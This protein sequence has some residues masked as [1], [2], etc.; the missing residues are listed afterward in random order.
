[1]PAT[2]SISWSSS[3]E[4]VIAYNSRRADG[5]PA[6][7]SAKQPSNPKAFVHGTATVPPRPSAAV[8]AAS[9]A[10]VI[11]LTEGDRAFFAQTL[12][13]MAERIQKPRITAATLAQDL[14]SGPYFLDNWKTGDIPDREEFKERFVSGLI[15]IARSRQLDQGFKFDRRNYASGPSYIAGPGKEDREPELTPTTACL[16][17]HDVRGIGKPSFNPIPMLAFDP[18]DNK[19]RE[20][21]LRNADARQKQ[22]VLERMLRRLVTDMDMPPEDSLEHE[23]FRKRDKASFDGVREFLETELKKLQ[24]D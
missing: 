12:A 21:W 7:A 5:D 17:C 3:A 6:V 19:A 13:D 11:G 18:F 15:A 16:R 4:K 23:L 2:L 10:R 20:Y 8:S 14:F 22:V 24:R 9:L 1:L